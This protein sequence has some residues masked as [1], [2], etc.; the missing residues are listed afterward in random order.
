MSSSKWGPRANISEIELHEFGL[1]GFK[2]IDI[3]GTT[4]LNLLVDRPTPY[5]IRVYRPWVVRQRV[6]GIR[7]IRRQLIQNGICVPKPM[8]ISQHEI[9]RLVNRWA[10]AETFISYIPAQCEQYSEV[11]AA[12]GRLH[13]AIFLCSNVIIPEHPLSNYGSVMQL[14]NWLKGSIHRIKPQGDQWEVVK[15][16][17]NAIRRLGELEQKHKESL[18]QM[19]IHGDYTLSNVGFTNDG[20]PVYLDFDVA[21]V[22]PRIYELAYALVVMLRTLNYY[23]SSSDAWHMVLNMINEYEKTSMMPLNSFEW[24]V[25]PREMARVTLCF[26]ARSGFPYAH[27]NSWFELARGVTESEQLMNIEN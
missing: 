14:S 21:D 8:Q 16:V 3:G 5:V 20:E 10:E 9:I 1:Q 4:N 7:D 26:S 27:K 24:L 18:P 11:F 25:L 2:V 13:K 12:L 6:L 15:R 19:L 23:I 17:S 22:R